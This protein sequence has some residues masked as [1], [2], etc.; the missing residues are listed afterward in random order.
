MHLDNIEN[1]GHKAEIAPKGAIL[2]ISGE[3]GIPPKESLREN[4]PETVK[5]QRFS[6]DNFYSPK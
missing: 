2:K 3:R 4:P 5:P 6:G 1:K